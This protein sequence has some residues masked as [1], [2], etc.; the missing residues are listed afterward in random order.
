MSVDHSI[1]D[2]TIRPIGRILT[3]FSHVKDC[4]PSGLS[5]QENSCIELD[6]DYVLGLRYAELTSHIIVLYWLDR[7]NRDRPVDRAGCS[8][9]ARGVFITRSPNRPNP[10]GFSVVKIIN[11]EGPKLIVSGLDCIDGSTVIDIKPYLPSEDMHPEAWIKWSPPKSNVLT[12]KD[13]T[14]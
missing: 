11:I 10:I 12:H 5:N 2:F 7:A 13:I 14:I 9:P 4:P 8:E 1:S 3:G 6:A